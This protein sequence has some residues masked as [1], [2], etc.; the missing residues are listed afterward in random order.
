MSEVRKFK[1]FARKHGME[2]PVYVAWSEGGVLARCGPQALPP[3][4]RRNPYPP[5]RRHDE[6]NRGAEVTSN[7]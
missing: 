3:R 4:L 1:R 5:G 7:D 2:H 6:W